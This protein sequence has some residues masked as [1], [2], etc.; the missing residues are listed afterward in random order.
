MSRKY[1]DDPLA[2]KSMSWVGNQIAKAEPRFQEYARLGF[3][4]AQ[5]RGG[6]KV[7]KIALKWFEAHPDPEKITI[8]DLIDLALSINEEL[9]ISEIF[10]TLAELTRITMIQG[11]TKKWIKMK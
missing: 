2:I 7:G 4:R 10:P 11:D 6:L 3:L 5:Q 1:Q 8:F 9:G